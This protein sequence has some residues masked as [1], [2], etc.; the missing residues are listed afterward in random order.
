MHRSPGS[1]GEWGLVPA[2]MNTNPF[3]HAGYKLASRLIKLDEALIKR[4]AATLLERKTIS[5][6]ELATWFK[7]HAQPRSL[8]ELE[9]SITF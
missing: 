8:D 4:P 7:D 5:E 3:A 1:G 9:K 6:E 2:V